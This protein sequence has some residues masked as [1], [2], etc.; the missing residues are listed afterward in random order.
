MSLKTKN[1]L[2]KET[3]FK[4]TSKKILKY[5][6]ILAV[7]VSS[8]LGVTNNANA[9]N[10]AIAA[11]AAI[12]GANITILNNA[13]NG[14][15]TI[16]GT[17]TATLATSIG[18]HADGNGSVELG[19]QSTAEAAILDINTTAAIGAITIE[20]NIRTKVANTTGTL[21]I[22]SAVIGGG[23]QVVTINGLV[24]YNNSDAVN[25]TSI[26]DVITVGADD[27]SGGEA[28][29]NAGVNAAAISINGGD[30]NETAKA[31]FKDVVVGTITL[32]QG[33]ST[34]TVVFNGST[35]TL[36]AGIT[37]GSDNEGLMQVTGTGITFTGAIGATGL[38]S[39]DIDSTATIANTLDA[40]I[41]DIATGA[42]LTADDA[43]AGDVTTV[44]GTGK[45]IF[46]TDAGGAATTA[47]TG[48][49]DSDVDGNGTLQF[50]NTSLTTVTGNVGVTKQIGTIDVDKSV[51]FVGIL[52]AAA[53]DVAAGATI[54]ID[55]DFTGAVTTLTTTAIL[56][57]QVD[58]GGAQVTTVTGTIDGLAVE[59]G[60]IKADNSGGVVF[61][62]KVG[63]IKSIGDVNID[64]LTTF[65]ESLSGET[66]NVA[67]SKVLNIKN[68]LTITDDS[69]ILGKVDFGGATAYDVSA[70][71]QDG[72]AAGNIAV[73]NTSAN[74]VTFAKKIGF[75]DGGTADALDKFVIAVSGTRVVLQEAG[76]E[77]DEVDF[78]DGA[79]L[80]LDRTIGSG[81]VVFSNA[82]DTLAADLDDGMK[83]FLPSNLKSGESLFLLSDVTTTTTM[84]AN[85]NKALQDNALFDYTAAAVDN[86]VG[87]NV[88]GDDDIQVTATARSGAAIG[89]QIGSDTNTAL[90]FLEAAAAAGDKV[91]T[92][93]I[94]AFSDV[95]NGTSGFLKT[96][97]LKLA[98]QVAP[99]TE[100][101]SGSTVAAR[102][103]SSSVQGIMS[104]RMA[105]LRSGDGYIGTGMSAGGA[106]SAK[107]GFIQAF[108]STAEQ[109]SK[110][111]GSGTQ[112]GF[113]S[114]ST[115][116]AIGF[117]GISDSGTTLGL[118][119]SMSNT[120]LDGKGA[121]KV[122][123]DM[124]TYTASIYMDKAT[125]VGYVEGSLTFGISENASTRNIT[126]A[127]LNRT[128]TG[129]Y[130]ASQ[131][132]LNIGVGM[133]NDVGVGYVT[134]FAS[135][136]G[137]LID[138]DA[139][140][141]KSTVVGDSLALKIAQDDV[142][143]MIGSVGVRYHNVM[144]NG[145]TPMIS[146]AL[147]NEFGDTTITSSN[148]YT[149]GGT[150]F[151]TS[152][153]VEELSAT[154]GL[155]YSMGNDYTSIEFAYEADANDDKY[156]SHG[157]SVKIVGKF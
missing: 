145:G 92:A 77:I 38:K 34:A 28:I 80:E 97:A 88:G 56:D 7:G 5:L 112:A 76:N 132:S 27:I 123:N 151:K 85:L 115:G 99:Q 100:L 9:A 82:T 131:L 157:G 134:P 10:L 83:I 1:N 43:F 138:T 48:A 49:I 52:D 57:F 37:A 32:N 65:N 29:F 45:I 40:R 91:D 130:D 70:F 143:S 71:L 133:P 140:T 15:L 67:A 44:N 39:L 137:T 95:L 110:T 106:M 113:D 114:D 26:M 148:T 125:D 152:T 23:P 120:D 136:T 154:L 24:G 79:I 16:N 73:T 90:G 46:S 3:G 98:E 142:S 126:S 19:D 150:K 84:A 78:E 33:I 121:G 156:L 104:N 54:T 64:E 11:D 124:D 87:D 68:G 35:R 129:A 147:N 109:K 75:N 53:V 116:V 47:V 66:M 36:A 59:G 18:S 12:N 6:P 25:A 8:T 102:G 20:S 93:A 30:A 149:G 86:A 94:D 69:E 146:L 117:D 135:F 62:G 55:D 101:I 141:E 51:T 118:S 72:G 111:V 139:Y 103:V 128:L 21:S 60:D 107:S 41:I 14:I 144:D 22:D 42:T 96:D 17:V 50:T 13:A 155:G 63:S 127:G 4:K 2:V 58:A 61:T 105:S 108:G 153:D 31:T 89:A 74:G 119:L 81:D 122:K